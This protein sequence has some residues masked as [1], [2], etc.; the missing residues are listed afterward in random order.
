MKG[1]ETIEALSTED[2]ERVKS[3]LSTNMKEAM[4]RE[5]ESEVQQSKLRAV[6]V[7]IRNECL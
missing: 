1:I 6:I 3:E 5:E 7:A 2:E 4:H